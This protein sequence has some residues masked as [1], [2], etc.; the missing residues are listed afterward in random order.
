M[1]VL[2]PGT[3]IHKLHEGLYAGSI[4]QVWMGED[5]DMSVT[6][7]GEFHDFHHPRV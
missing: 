2:L 4:P 5:P 3:L 6:I 1:M 7:F